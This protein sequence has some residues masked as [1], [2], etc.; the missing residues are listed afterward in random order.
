MHRTLSDNKIVPDNSNRRRCY[1]DQSNLNTDREWSDAELLELGRPAHVRNFNKRDRAASG[2]RSRRCPRQS[3]RDWPGLPLGGVTTS[4]STERGR[5]RQYFDKP[6]TVCFL[7]VGT[8]CP[9]N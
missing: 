7:G 4:C 1:G 8:R 3:R 6:I 5:R 2:T 9:K